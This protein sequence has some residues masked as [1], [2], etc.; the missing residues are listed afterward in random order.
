MRPRNFSRHDTPRHKRGGGGGGVSPVEMSVPLL[1]LPSTRPRTDCGKQLKS[2]RFRVVSLL[3]GVDDVVTGVVEN[4]SLLP[5]DPLRAS[6]NGRLNESLIILS[7]SGTSSEDLFIDSTHDN[8]NIA[9]I[10]FHPARG[11][12]YSRIILHV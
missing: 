2:P 3:N 4:S 12:D 5:L 10:K 1:R 11:E 6:N 9:L 8:F 7:T